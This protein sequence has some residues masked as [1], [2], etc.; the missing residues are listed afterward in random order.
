MITLDLE[1]GSGNSVRCGPWEGEIQISGLRAKY[2]EPVIIE[3]R[4][5][6]AGQVL[7]KDTYP[8]I[9]ITLVH[10]GKLSSA[11]ANTIADCL[12]YKGTFSGDSYTDPCG[13]VPSHKAIVTIAA[14][15]GIDVV[16]APN[17]VWGMDYSS[18]DKNTLALKGT[19][20]RP[21]VGGDP[22]DATNQPLTIT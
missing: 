7:G 3:D 12:L 8:E 16:T 22:D 5:T 15:D 13:K 4:G 1:T 10:K 2:K 20:Y 6:Y 18:G 19:C 9:S 21:Q 14:P 11:V 17:S